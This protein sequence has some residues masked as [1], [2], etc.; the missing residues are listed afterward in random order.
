MTVDELISKLLDMP[1]NAPVVV[2]GVDY[3]EEVNAEIVELAEDEER[4]VI[5]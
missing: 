4:V 5:R 1:G 3:P 2:I